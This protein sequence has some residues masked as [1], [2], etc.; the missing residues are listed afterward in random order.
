[1]NGTVQVPLADTKPNHRTDKKTAPE[2]NCNNAMDLY[3]YKVRRCKKNRIEFNNSET[4]R[5][6]ILNFIKREGIQMQTFKRTAD[7]ERK[8]KEPH[9]DPSKSSLQAG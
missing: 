2:S 6:S 7:R 3:K 1:M 8:K 4:K 5:F 9:L